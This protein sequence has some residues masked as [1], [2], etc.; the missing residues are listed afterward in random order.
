MAE[1]M[2]FEEFR[3]AIDKH[4]AELSNA[5]PE[6]VAAAAAPVEAAIDRRLPRLTG[7]LE[8]SLETEISSTPTQATAIVQIAH[9]AV[10]E[11]EEKAVFL[12]FGT[13]HAPAEP[14]FRPGFEESKD[15]A[16]AILVDGL[17]KVI[18]K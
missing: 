11:A 17:L 14:S 8:K 7:D 18:N 13:S 12:E 15:K 5:L 3:A 6:V 16:A 4:L 2:G 1:L 10:G 9:S